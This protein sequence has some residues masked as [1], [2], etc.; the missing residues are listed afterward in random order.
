MGHTPSVSSFLI[1]DQVFRQDTGKWCIIGVFNRILAGRFPCVHPS[2]GLFVRLSDA[3]GDYEVRVDYCD[4]ED[5]VITKLEGI[6]LNVRDRLAN[7]EL[8][9][10]TYNLPIKAPGRYFFRLYFNNEL[11]GGDIALEVAKGET[12]PPV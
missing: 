11:A 8:G 10:Q 12:H 5:R 1:A 4:S 9:I 2:L 3:L 7:V 6:R